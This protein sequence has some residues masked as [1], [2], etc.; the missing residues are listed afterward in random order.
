[1][2]QRPQCRCGKCF[3]N[4]INGLY[5]CPQCLNKYDFTPQPLFDKP[6]ADPA[7]TALL[8]AL[9]GISTDRGNIDRLSHRLRYHRG[10]R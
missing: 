8:L 6:R 4:G 9:S 3:P 10:G 2:G 5:T 7:V 1:M